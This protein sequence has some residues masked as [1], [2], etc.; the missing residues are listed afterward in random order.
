MTRKAHL[1]LPS[2]HAQTLIANFQGTPCVALDAALVLAGIEI[3]IR[4]QTSYWDGAIIAAAERLRAPILYS[5]DL[6][7]GQ[8]YG[9]VTVVNPFK[10]C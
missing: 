1:Q 9:G 3:S 5:E 4:C 2:S 6:A 10:G 7:D 8:R